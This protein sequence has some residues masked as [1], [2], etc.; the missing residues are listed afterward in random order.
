M[1]FLKKVEIKGL[2]GSRTFGVDLHKDVNIF[3]GRNGT[4]KTT[5]INIISAAL[6]LNL[7]ELRK[8]EYESI[9]LYFYPKQN[10]AIPS[11]EIKKHFIDGGF[12]IEYCVKQK[13][14]DINVFIPIYDHRISRF[15]GVGRKEMQ[16]DITIARKYIHDTSNTIW[17][18]IDRKSVYEKR[19]EGSDDGLSSLD[20]NIEI[21]EQKFFEY[22]LD[23]KNKETLEQIKFQKD[24][25][26]SSI[27]IPKWSAISDSL[28]KSN[29]EE[30]KESALVIFSQ[31]GISDDA[32]KKKIE[33]FFGQIESSREAL[34]ASQ[35]TLDHMFS[36]STFGNFVSI[37]SNWNQTQGKIEGIYSKKERFLNVFNKL[38]HYKKL[39]SVAGK[40]SAT[41]ESGKELSL[42]QLSSGERQMFILLATP[43]FSGDDPIIY[44]A[45]EPELSLHVE[46]QESLISNILGINNNV[47]VLFA[48]HSPDIVSQYAKNVFDMER[49]LA[50]GYE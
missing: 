31:F 8:I 4:G 11:I 47:Q 35:M 2:W 34:N 20:K 3:T 37:K 28:N 17:L 23:L 46:W 18:S 50:R 16:D 10:N 13:Q 38:M 9:K 26:L 43:F 32:S 40:L 45:D 7:R 41:T 44:I 19:S 42:S 1:H 48:T 29:L 21:L 22:E 49:V 30:L 5:L 27:N 39:K 6:R 33:K 14:S 36:L 15:R 25:F 12:F 24:F